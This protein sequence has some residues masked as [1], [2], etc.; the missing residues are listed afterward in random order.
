M[1]QM[2]PFIKSKFEMFFVC[3]VPGVIDLSSVVQNKKLKMRLTGL[4]GHLSTKALS[5]LQQ[6]EE[7][8]IFYS[9]APVVK[10]CNIFVIKDLQAF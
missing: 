5:L 1:C 9:I 8:R 6:L 10:Y 7:P 4:D 3:L 2:W